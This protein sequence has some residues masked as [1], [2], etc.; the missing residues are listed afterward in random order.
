MLYK[1]QLCLLLLCCCISRL[2]AQNR[3]LPPADTV[4]ISLDS[5]ES[6]FVSNNLQLLAQRYN[7]DVVKALEIQARLYP[8]PNFTIASTIYNP[9]AKKFFPAPLSTDGEL[10]GNISQVIVLAGKINKNFKLA[11]A[12]SRLSEYEFFDL[13]RTLKYSLRSTFYSIYYL[14]QS[15]AVYQL[16]INNLQVV[17]TAYND[18]EVKK[19]ISEKEVVRV[20]A[21]LYSLQNEY[22]G[23]IDQINDAESQLRLLVQEKAGTYLVPQLDDKKLE[24]GNPLQ[25][26]LAVLVDSAY[27]GRTDLMI[28]KANT[29]I[30]KLNYNYQKALAVP[31]LTASIS[32]DQQGSYIHNYSALG[33]AI[34]LPFFSRNQGNIKSAKAAIKMNEATE[35][36]AQLTVEENVYRALQKAIDADNLYKKIDP[37]FGQDYTRLVTAAVEH[38]KR[39]EMGLLDFLDFYDSYKQTTLQVNAIKYNKINAL[40]GINFYTGSS[41]F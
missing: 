16:E 24:S 10:S 38:Y 12:N 4:R 13:L 8:N 33:L 39:R 32:Y 37:A 15:A 18:P 28:A 6:R 35:Q 17:V 30:S 2:Q 26:P 3:T 1:K 20:K 31:D 21:Q 14:Q 25:Y 22:Q 41:F 40:E 34:D 29:D 27:K 11:Q 7:V 9:N 23:L 36:S 19:Y 5:A